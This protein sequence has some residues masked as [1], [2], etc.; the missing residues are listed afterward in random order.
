M[1][2]L[3][4]SNDTLLYNKY[5]LKKKLRLHIN[6]LNNIENIL[7]EDEGLFLENGYIKPNSIKFLKRSIGYLDVELL[8]ANMYFDV[9]YEAFVNDI[10]NNDIYIGQIQKIR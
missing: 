5:I 4:V 9:I 7:K 3:S 6:D 2:S 8:N 1:E 10:K